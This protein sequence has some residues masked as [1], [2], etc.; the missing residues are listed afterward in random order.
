M[1]DVSEHHQGSQGRAGPT[2]EGEMEAGAYMAFLRLP[3]NQKEGHE[4][5]DHGSTVSPR[6]YLS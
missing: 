2:S 4:E 3:E 1:A 6:I 5:V